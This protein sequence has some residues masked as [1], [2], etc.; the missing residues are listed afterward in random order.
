MTIKAKRIDV[1]EYLYRGYIIR[2]MGTHGHW[3]VYADIFSEASDAGDT[4]A[5][6]K[7]IVDA[8]HSREV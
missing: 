1:G 2:R 6:A 3:N 5:E 7:Q 8:Y 4:L